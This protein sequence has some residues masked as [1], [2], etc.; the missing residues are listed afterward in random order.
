MVLVHSW[1][2]LR[3]G[4]TAQRHRSGKTVHRAE[5]ETE[6]SEQQVMAAEA[7]IAAEAEA[8]CPFLSCYIPCNL[9]TYCL[10]PLIL[11]VGYFNPRI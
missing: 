4:G 5:G 6:G 7:K 3:Q 8:F 1:L 2:T 10:V 11:K 9:Q